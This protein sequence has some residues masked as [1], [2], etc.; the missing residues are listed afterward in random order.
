[1]TEYLQKGWTDLFFS[2]FLIVSQNIHILLHQVAVVDA[3]LLY[4]LVVELSEIDR[5]MQVHS[6][7]IIC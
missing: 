5:S 7:R 1:M 6:N 3:L 4:L 2:F